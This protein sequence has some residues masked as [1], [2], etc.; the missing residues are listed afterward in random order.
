MR[1]QTCLWPYIQNGK[2][3]R[4]KAMADRKFN[5][6]KKMASVNSIKVGM[7]SVLRQIIASTH[8]L[9]QTA[10]FRFVCWIN[11]FV[12]VSNGIMSKP[13]RHGR[14]QSTVNDKVETDWRKRPER[15]RSARLFTDFL[16]SAFYFYD[17]RWWQMKVDTAIGIHETQH[18]AT[19]VFGAYLSFALLLSVF[20]LAC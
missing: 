5:I 11:V 19:Q 3:N 16:F 15:T 6:E 9:T 12:I 2:N 18:R 20:S 14:M 8:I 17:T 10:A 7:Y 4:M 1:S 13:P